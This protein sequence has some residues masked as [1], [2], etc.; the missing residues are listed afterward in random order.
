MCMV[1]CLC[2]TAVRVGL[3]ADD[4]IDL[5][6]Y[7]HDFTGELALFLPELGYLMGTGLPSGGG[8]EG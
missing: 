4:A 7:G 6:L 2:V 3:H 8:A 5:P 1:M